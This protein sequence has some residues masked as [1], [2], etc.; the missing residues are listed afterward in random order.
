[1][2]SWTHRAQFI[3]IFFRR[4]QTTIVTLLEV[5]IRERPFS[6]PEWQPQYGRDSILETKRQGRKMI[7]LIPNSSKKNISILQRR[8]KS[9]R[10]YISTHKLCIT[11]KLK[12][13]NF[14]NYRFINNDMVTFISKR[15][16]KYFKTSYK[17]NIQV[18]VSRIKQKTMI[19][20]TSNN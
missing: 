13:K 7:D 4:Q 14:L 12:A 8:F 6:E 10:P 16:I 15:E 5:F 11:S 2:Y 1:M 9:I 3:L 17:S 19:S 18:M 20:I